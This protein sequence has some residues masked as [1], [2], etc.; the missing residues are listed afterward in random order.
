MSRIL[1]VDDE[2]NI[3]MVLSEALNGA[4][5][6]EIAADGESAVEKLREGA[7]DLVLT[8]LRMGEVGGLE[9][10]KEAKGLNPRCG[11]MIL[12]AYSSV[13]NAVEAM[14]MGADDY[15]AKPFSLEAV[16]E[17]VKRLLEI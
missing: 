17:K 14:K 12:T 15:L 2:E 16:E 10:L 6:V 5:D 11:V 9:V 1:V 8:D 3:R 13:D 7:F 4:Y